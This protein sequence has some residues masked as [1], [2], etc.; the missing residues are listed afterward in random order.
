MAE[1]LKLV[2][3]SDEGSDI[4]SID[5][6]GLVAHEGWSQQVAM[7]GEPVDD[8]ITLHIA[9]ASDDH[10]A[11]LIQKL[12]TFIRRGNRYQTNSLDKY[13]MWL[14]AQISGETNARQ[15]YVIEARRNSVNVLDTFMEKHTLAND[16]LGLKRIG[17]WED[18]TPTTYE[19]SSGLATLGGM[20]QFADAVGGD[21]DGR[22][23]EAVF[24]GDDNGPAADYMDKVWFGLR[25]ERY[26]N[27]ANFV[28][29][30]EAE[31][32]TKLN[33][34]ANST[35]KDA[36]ASPS[37]AGT[38]KSVNLPITSTL[39]LFWSRGI[40]SISPSNYK[41]LRGRFL[42]LGRF[43]VSGAGTEARVRLGTGTGSTPTLR[44][45]SR[46]LVTDTDWR[47]IELGQVDIPCNVRTIYEETVLLGQR[48]YL[49]AEKIAG[50]GSLY[51]DCLVLIPVDEGFICQS[52]GTVSAFNNY[53][54]Y[55][56]QGPDGHSTAVSYSAGSGGH[57]SNIDL[58]FSG[59]M[60][61][62]K[63][64]GVIAADYLAG[65]PRDELLGVK[66]SV[67]KRYTTFRG[68]S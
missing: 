3:R 44:T 40:T 26:G 18:L 27:P 49:E 63:V 56:H 39:T 67:L 68:V 47:L 60:P 21:L 66:L 22:I 25:S 34:A 54:T 53:K 37:G 16:T 28:P 10:L 4:D 15:S 51:F 2:L 61:T 65:Q 19:V 55:V 6:L 31:S 62:G 17:A 8:V 29:V 59:G 50:S 64:Y 33:G 43:C 36:S 41:D 1:Q 46:A 11:T 42:V 52:G 5:L 12:D 14:R 57:T 13:G 30:W 9:A 58:T 32:G 48:F 24:Y 20:A 35:A 23:Y 38:N 7:N 45:Y